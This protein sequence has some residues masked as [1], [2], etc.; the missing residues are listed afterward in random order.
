MIP[1]TQFGWKLWKD[2]QVETKKK[3]LREKIRDLAQF[4]QVPLPDA[5]DAAKLKSDAAKEYAEAVARLAQI[6]ALDKKAAPAIASGAD[7]GDTAGVAVPVGITAVE[8]KPAAPPPP[9]RNWIQ[10]WF[11]LYVPKRPLAWIPQTF[12]FVVLSVTVFGAIGILSQPKDPELASG[13]LG[14]V[15]F[16][17]IALLFR[18]WAVRANLDPSERGAQSKRSRRWVPVT[19]TIA[20]IVYELAFF[21]GISTDEHDNLSFAAMRQNLVAIVVSSLVVGIIVFVAWYRWRRRTQQH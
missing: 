19:V 11:L 8:I 6:T 20:G 4:L 12:Y 15:M 18:L 7:K 13:I 3:L 1:A 9:A 10:R 5:P 14:L 2:R 21:V 16:F 17:G